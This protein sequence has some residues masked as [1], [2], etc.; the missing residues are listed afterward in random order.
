MLILTAIITVVGLVRRKLKA[1]KATT[2]RHADGRETLVAGRSWRQRLRR[3]ATDPHGAHSPR[4]HNR[5]RLEKRML[6]PAFAA[7]TLA[8]VAFMGVELVTC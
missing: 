1:D 8:V 7:A 3:P 5:F 2:N 4:E 6:Q